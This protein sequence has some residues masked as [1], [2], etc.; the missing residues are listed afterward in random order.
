MLPPLTWSV[1]TSNLLSLKMKPPVKRK[2]GP[3]GA[4]SRKVL[5][6]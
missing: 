3:S 2:N 6:F 1:W 4:K 5:R